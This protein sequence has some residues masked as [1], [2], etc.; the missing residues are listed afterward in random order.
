MSK[1][2][3]GLDYGTDSCRAI[4]VDAAN[5]KEIASAVKYYPR[6]MKGYYCDPHTNRYRQHPLDYIEVL[7]ES[8]REA[9]SR[10]PEGTAGRQH[11]KTRADAGDRG[12]E[13]ACHA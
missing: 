6:W 1:Y 9:L 12:R 5:G 2:V 4:I 3:I 13:I 10:S 8:I 11:A 7:E